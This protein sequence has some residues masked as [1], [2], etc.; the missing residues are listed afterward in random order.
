MRLL[1]SRR[2]KKEASFRR[3]CPESQQPGC[4]KFQLRLAMGHTEGGSSTGLAASPSQTSWITGGFRTADSGRESAD[5][6]GMG[7]GLGVRKHA[8]RPIRGTRPRG[9][10]CSFPGGTFNFV[11][12]LTR[13][14][15]SSTYFSAIS[16]R[17][18]SCISTS[19]SRRHIS[20]FSVPIVVLRTA[21]GKV[22]PV[23]SGL[24]EGGRHFEP[25]KGAR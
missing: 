13:L 24:R 4:A 10:I 18:S 1:L 14:L 20:Y 3:S 11:Q 21:S 12:F 16:C 9:Q 23:A 8:S 2:D 25:G 22:L 15:V 17:H 6:E 5:S 7:W 19:R